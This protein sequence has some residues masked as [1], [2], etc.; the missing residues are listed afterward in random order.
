M[1]P[2]K[3]YYSLIQ[4]CPDLGR[5]EAANIGV[6]LF[7]PERYFLKALTSNN[8]RHIIRF[9][10]NEGHDWVRINSFKIGL[11]DRIAIEGR[12][13][14]T[15][16]QV[17]KFIAGRANLLQITLP[18]PMKVNDP[19]EDLEALFKELVAEPSRSNYPPRP[20]PPS[21]ETRQISNPH[22]DFG[23]SPTSTRLH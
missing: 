18:R 5:L 2:A 15:L 16:E 7:C 8:N 19:N 17:E 23:A 1:N 11:A 9:F 3:G 21:A 6:L 14:L 13:I 20:P 22:P 12:D 10:G 4:Y